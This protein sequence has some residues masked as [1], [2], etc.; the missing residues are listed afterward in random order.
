[1]LFESLCLIY[2]TYEILL[3][4]HPFLAIEIIDLPLTNKIAFYLLYNII[5]A[6]FMPN[7]LNRS[8]LIKNIQIFIRK[9]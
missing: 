9:M 5:Y 8:K 1:M 6:R 3:R 4:A 7:K 2:S